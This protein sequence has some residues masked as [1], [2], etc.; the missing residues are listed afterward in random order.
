[1]INI[2]EIGMIFFEFLGDSGGEIAFGNGVPRSEI[3]FNRI[4]GFVD[5]NFGGAGSDAEGFGVDFERFF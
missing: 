5:E 3:F 2:S 1:M 4:E